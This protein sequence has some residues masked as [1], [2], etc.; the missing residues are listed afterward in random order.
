MT[1]PARRQGRVLIVDDEKS[2]REMLRK[3][4]EYENY[5]PVEAADGPEALRALAGGGFDA[6][7]L[8]IRMPGMDG[9]EVLRK[10]SRS[11]PK[12]R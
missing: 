1:D 9:M 7:L 3:V 6:M 4:L 5:G 8:D 2:V 10:S 11:I 12:S